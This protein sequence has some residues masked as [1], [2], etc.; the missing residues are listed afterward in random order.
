VRT[1]YNC[2]KICTCMICCAPGSNTNHKLRVVFH[3]LCQDVVS[4]RVQ[5]F[6]F[7]GGCYPNYSLFCGFYTVEKLCFDVLEESMSL[8]FQDGCIC[9]QLMLKYCGGKTVSVA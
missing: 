1:S 4:N 7:W 3:C 5:V 6:R 9:F 2:L 8:H